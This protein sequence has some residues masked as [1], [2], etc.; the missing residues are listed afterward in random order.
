MPKGK[1]LRVPN[2]PDAFSWD[3]LPLED[4]ARHDP[5]CFPG[6]L[7]NVEAA[8]AVGEFRPSSRYC[9]DWEM[10]FKL[11]LNHGAA[12]TNRVVANYREHH[13]PG[14][15]TTDIDVSGRKYT[16][17]NMQR[18]R[19]FAL[20]RKRKFDSRFDRR[21]ILR[22]S[23]MATRYLLEHGRHFSS[24]MLRYNAGLLFLSVAPHSRYRFFQ[25]V[26]QLLSWRSLRGSSWLFYL[27]Q[28]A[29]YSFT[30][31]G[32]SRLRIY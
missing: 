29:S 18:K 26:T 7:F 28:R 6:Q 10:W 20:L 30:K 22:D 11:A 14:R 17:G 4:W 19:H 12:A 9:A 27:L 1:S 16:C 21:A 31:P 2:Q 23:P 13:S 5:V 8:R 25:A 3:E 24:R 32:G 15:G